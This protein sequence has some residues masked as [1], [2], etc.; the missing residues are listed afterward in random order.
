MD[1]DAGRSAMTVHVSRE[2]LHADVTSPTMGSEWPPTDPMETRMSRQGMTIADDDSLPV[3]VPRSEKTLGVTSPER[4]RQLRKHLV[5]SLR[6]LR[7]MQKP[8]RLS[9][10]RP[11]PELF[12]ARVAQTACA[13]CKGWCCKGGGEHAYLDERTMARVR[14]QRPE[15]DARQVL[16]LYAD[17][18]PERGYDHSCLFHG[19]RG[20]TLD[21]SLRSDVCNNYFCRG[22]ED[23]VK[24][25]DAGTPVIVIAGEGGRM[26][27]SPVLRP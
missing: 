7:S 17:R 1:A 2:G 23:Y 26:R 6:A 22:L 19:E 4:V 12:V 14:Q 24:A 11:E 3:M 15:L 20:C 18:V 21:R 16:R 10:Q 8:E 9:P 5:T 25:G 13:L 27:T